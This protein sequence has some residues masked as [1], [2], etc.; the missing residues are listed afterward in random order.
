MKCT[1]P[2]HG[3]CPVLGRE[4]PPHLHHLCQTR[5]DYRALFMR[6]VKEAVR[7]ALP[8]HTEQEPDDLDIEE[9]PSCCSSSKI[10]EA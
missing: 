2:T 10:I 6:H 1:C 9:A 7:L 5:S 4:M 3:F 8:S